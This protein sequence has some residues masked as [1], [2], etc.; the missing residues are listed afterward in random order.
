MEAFFSKYEIESTRVEAISGDSLRFLLPKERW[1][2]RFYAGCLLSHLQCMFVSKQRSE[3]RILILEDDVVPIKNF[4]ERFEEFSCSSFHD[5]VIWDMLYLGFIPVTDD[6]SFWSYNLLNGKFL[7]GHPNFFRG[8]RWLTG[9]YS[10]A[11]NSRMRDHLLEELSV[12]KEFYCG[13]D[14]WLRNKSRYDKID[15]F[16]QNA[17]FG[18]V[19][20]LFAHGDGSS[21][22]L[23][24]QVMERMRRSIWS[25]RSVD[26]YEIFE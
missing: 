15:T 19:P 7:Q 23:P 9:A 21:T 13:I 24:D 11:L 10:Y 17:I 14:A 8:E 25:S 3:E 12:H 1:E 4:N 22:T 5:E 6:D 26:D 2:S 20:Q 16:G 18:Y